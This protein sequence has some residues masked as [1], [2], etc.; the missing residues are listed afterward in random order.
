MIETVAG[1]LD[2][3][4]LAPE[5]LPGAHKALSKHN[6]NQYAVRNSTMWRSGGSTP[7]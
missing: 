5:I 6:D 3:A 2:A 1:T 4:S 7:G